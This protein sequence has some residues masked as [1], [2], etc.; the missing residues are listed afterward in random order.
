[1]RI[2]NSRRS[3]AAS[4]AVRVHIHVVFTCGYGGHIYT[5]YLG[6][7]GDEYRFWGALFCEYAMRGAPPPHPLQLVSS[8]MKCTYTITAN[9]SSL[10]ILEATGMNIAGSVSIF[11][12]T[13]SE[14]VPHPTQVVFKNIKRADAVTADITIV[15]WRPR[16]YN[17]RFEDPNLR[18]RNT[19][20]PA[21]APRSAY[22]LH[23]ERVKTA[24]ASESGQTEQF[25]CRGQP[26]GR[27][28]GLADRP[29]RQTSGERFFADL[30]DRQ[31]RSR[32]RGELN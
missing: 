17:R 11:A 4:E 26:D 5:S 20:R 21:A 30:R 7:H 25:K 16:G 10:R 22:G 29:G 13:Q 18:I 24:N 8:N 2:R 27:V 6:G 14:A 3:T 9:M 23:I 19:R 32:L 28:H 15:S 12:N 1:M 31:R